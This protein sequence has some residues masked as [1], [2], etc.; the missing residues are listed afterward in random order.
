M[1]NQVI[2][3]NI[4]SASVINNEAKINVNVSKNDDSIVIHESNS[5]L[6]SNSTCNVKEDL[7][8]MESSSKLLD[9][10]P[11]SSHVKNMDIESIPEFGNR[12]LLL[13]ID[14]GQNYINLLEAIKIDLNIKRM[15]KLV[16]RYLKLY[17]ESTDFQKLR[18]YLAQNER[19]SGF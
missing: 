8:S 1:P 9:E 17:T 2:N 11:S 13:I 3:S 16:Y 4:S 14:L 6:N 5:N 10:N 15:P 7:S 18:D 12:C 19:A